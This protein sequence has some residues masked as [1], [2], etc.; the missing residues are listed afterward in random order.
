VMNS[1]DAHKALVEAGVEPTP[2]SPEEM[3]TYMVR[4]MAR[5]GKVVKDAGV[6]L[7]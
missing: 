4:E 7:E 2:S 6:K 1:P 3:S 5:W